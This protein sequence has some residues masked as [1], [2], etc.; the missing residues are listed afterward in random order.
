MIS[1][2]PV[3]ILDFGADPTGTTDSAAAIQAA[4][5]S[6]K[7]NGGD[8]YIPAGI[9]RVNS[10]LD[11]TG[12]AAKSV[13]FIGAGRRTS[14]IYAYHSGHVFDCTGSQ[15]LLF[16]DIGV[17]GLT[18]FPQTAFFFAR[19][20]TNAS[21]GQNYLNRVQT[22]GTYTVAAIYNYAAEEFHMDDCYCTNS[23][24]GAAVLQITRNNIAGLASTFKT[25]ATGNQSTTQYDFSGCAFNSY[26]TSGTHGCIQLQ[27]VSAI[28]FTN[29]FCVNQSTTAGASFVW[30]D[31][32][33]YIQ[34]VMAFNDV[35]FDGAGA[36]IGF[37][38]TGTQSW[39]QIQI[40]SL[41]NYSSSIT[42][43]IQADTGSIVQ[44]LNFSN[45]SNAKEIYIYQANYCD[46]ENFAA[47]TV[48]YYISDS[49]ISTNSATYTVSRADFS[50]NNFVQ[51][52]DT[53]VINS[54][55]SLSI[56]NMAWNVS[57]FRMGAYYLWV[58]GSGRLRIKNGAPASDTDG[59]VV[60]TQ[61]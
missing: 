24:A 4:I 13:S 51:F 48:N 19:L 1:G 2:S 42:R 18:P 45:C 28:S 31:N 60:G 20:S 12:I 61:T 52:Y 54:T 59:T 41:L 35:M 26:A 30:L 3:N 9:F 44:F 22:N 55:G 58:D 25:V 36:T 16:Q 38:L 21:A 37:K 8:I 57:T 47:V 56:S 11:V 49:K 17:W 15:F 39:S 32:T 53:N 10:A 23:Y 5:N 7:T 33:T 50:L 43:M 34:Q 46:I 29:L 14:L 6:V 27:G 40:A